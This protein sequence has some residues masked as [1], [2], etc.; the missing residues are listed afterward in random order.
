LAVWYHQVYQILRR[1]YRWLPEQVDG[2]LLNRLTKIVEELE[3]EAEESKTPDLD[4]DDFQ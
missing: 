2:I 1:K 3:E 4:E